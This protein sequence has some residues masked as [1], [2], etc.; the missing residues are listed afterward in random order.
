MQLNKYYRNY[1]VIWLFPNS[2]CL[3]YEVTHKKYNNF[4]HVNTYLFNKT[5]KNLITNNTYEKFKTLNLLSRVKPVF[6]K[7]V[8]H[9]R[10][11]TRSRSYVVNDT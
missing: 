1:N 5:L 3:L 8:V 4:I 10:T 7:N 11:F 2:D 6:G 9:E